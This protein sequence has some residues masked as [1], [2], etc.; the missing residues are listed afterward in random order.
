MRRLFALALVS[1]LAACGGSSSSSD[2]DAAGGSGSGSPDAAITASNG[3]SVVTPDITI[4]PGQ[5]ITYCYYFHTANTSDVVVK[6][7]Q[8]T[9]AEGSHHLILYFQK[10][11]SQPDGTL[12]PSGN[13]GGAS[14][15]DVSVWTY[16]SSQATQQTA[17]PA[18]D[19]NGKPVGMLVPAGQAAVMQ[20]HYINSTE[21]P[22]I[23]HASVLAN[24]YAPGT[25]YTA[26][27]AY[28]SYNN[29][30][31][32][33]PN[34]AATVSA[35]CTTPPGAKFF[36]MSTHSHKQMTKDTVSDSTGVFLT[37]TD[38]EHPTIMSWTDAPFY[39]FSGNSFTYSC[40]YQSMSS[41]PID[42]GPSAATNEMCM[43]VGYFFPATAPQICFTTGG[44]T[45]V[46]AN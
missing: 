31:H 9:L 4:M 29:D 30:I 11:N 40:E 41:Q 27:A 36:T 20:L 38:W 43:A 39:A 26:A 37:T 14:G 22:I 13:C 25:A 5:E 16:S 2:V 45:F 10:S 1:S 24:G 18:D 32:I 34:S 35:T 44:R 17:L 7:W 12:D 3:F 6:N 15:T 28:V 42:S 46:F 21:Q 33:K 23:A 8:S 19:G